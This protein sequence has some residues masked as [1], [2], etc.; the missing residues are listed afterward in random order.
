MPK[1]LS[2][3]VPVY[4]VERYLNKCLDSILNQTFKDFELILVNDG[5]RDKSGEICDRYEKVDKRIKVIH[6]DN[7][8]LSS[9]R[10]AGLNIAEGDYIAFVDSDDFIHYRMYEILINTAIKKKSDITMCKYMDAFEHEIYDL[11]GDKELTN[12]IDFSNLEF[13]SQLYSKNGVQFV[14]IGRAHV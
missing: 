7:G 12:T 3:I 10:N 8:G 14:E 4:N 6:K 5:S 2:I 11:Q 9:A 13:L 1:A